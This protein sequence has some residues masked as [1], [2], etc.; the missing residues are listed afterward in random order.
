MSSTAS[1]HQPDVQISFHETKPATPDRSCARLAA[2]NR[3]TPPGDPGKR[4][5]NRTILLFAAFL[6]DHLVGDPEWF[7][8]PVRLIGSAIAGGEKTLRAPGD[9]ACQQFVTGAT[10]SITLL[11][12]SY[13]ATRGAI[14]WAYRRSS[15][16]GHATE[17]LLAWTTLAARN[18]QQEGEEVSASLEMN[19]LPMARARLA[20]IVGRDTATLD[21]SEISRALIETLAESTSDG[22]IAPLLYLALGGVPLAMAYK[23][24]NT[25][26]SMIGHRNQR[27]LYFGKFAARLDDVANWVPARLTALS[28]IGAAA[29]SSD[30]SMHAAWLTWLSDGGAHESPNA[31]QPEAAAAGALRV[32]LGG[33][34]RY[35]GEVHPGRTI[36]NTF[37]KPTPQK[38]KNALR[39]TS[40]AALIGLAGAILLTTWLSFCCREARR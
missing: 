11:T 27:Y 35:D 32:R 26:D 2:P 25:L 39:L 24:V 34:N 31:G 37:S 14:C 36:G 8:H 10:L 21:A 38:A 29:I 7:P 15:T 18:L 1:S 20:R 40:K 30:L 23:A 5:L 28:V 3:S 19:D 4:M 16:L 12:L 13:I 33:S 6:L 22:I 9:T 17:L